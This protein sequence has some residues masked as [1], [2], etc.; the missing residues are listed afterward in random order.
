MK[1]CKVIAIANQKGGVGKTTT[2]IN[3]AACLLKFNKKVL[4]VD[5]DPQSNTTAAM[6]LRGTSTVCNLISDIVNRQK[7][8]EIQQCIHNVEGI[9]V[10][11]CDISLA[12]LELYIDKIIS[13]E[14]VLKRILST[15]K[16][17]YDVVIIDALPS[18]S[19]LAVNIF[20]ATDYLIIPM[21]ANDAYSLSAFSAILSSVEEIK[22][23]INPN[24]K[25]VGELV[26]MFD[27]RNKNDRTI[28]QL[29]K[30]DVRTNPFSQTIPVSTKIAEANKLCKTIFEHAPKSKAAEAYLE[31]TREVLQRI[32]LSADIKYEEE[33]VK[34]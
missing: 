27:G 32:G 30:E 15:V 20:A 18:L 34:C 10:L 11:P 13:R 22:S 23:E 14:T 29:I 8:I 2:A 28:Y 16:L 1:M 24:I 26:T 4:L 12:T 33:N 31:F 5:F 21:K 3:L 25:I 6:G 9:D 17:N 7:T 19:M